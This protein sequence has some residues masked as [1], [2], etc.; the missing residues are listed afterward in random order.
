MRIQQQKTNTR[1]RAI[2]ENKR[3]IRQN[4]RAMSWRE[5]TKM[6]ITRH[7]RQGYLSEILF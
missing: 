2:S 1:L 6:D 4:K 7:P 3:A 5:K